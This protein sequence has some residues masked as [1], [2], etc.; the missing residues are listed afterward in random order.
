M[1]CQVYFVILI[2]FSI[3]IVV[4]YN[5]LV[6][7]YSSGIHVRAGFRLRAKDTSISVYIVRCSQECLDTQPVLFYK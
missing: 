4:Y 7:I 5:A 6:N 2:L 3:D 1:V